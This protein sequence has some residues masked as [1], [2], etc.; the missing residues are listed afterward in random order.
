MFHRSHNH[1]GATSRGLAAVSLGI[2]MMELLAPRTVEGLLGI[3]DR[4]Q[5]RGILRVL[6]IRELMHGVSLLADDGDG[7]RTSA[8]VWSRVAGDVLDTALL[9]AAGAKTRRPA[10]F[11]AVAG[12][13][14]L[15]GA[16]DLLAA[17]KHSANA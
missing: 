11:A 7:R 16:C 9:A 5:H 15:I 2:G 1:D 17:T 6:G 3:E 8:G 13:A 10:S 12:S 14:L 4:A